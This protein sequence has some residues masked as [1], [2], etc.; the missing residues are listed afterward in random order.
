MKNKSQP[1]QQKNL[2]EDVLELKREQLRLLELQLKM[3]EGLPHLYGWKWYSW[4]WDFFESQNKENFL[5]AANQI[6]KS[7]TMI[8]KF[9]HWATAPD[10]WAG[11]W[12]SLQKGQ[13]PNQFWY[14]YPTQEVATIEFE[15]KWEPLFLPKG[16]Y[17]NSPQYGWKEEWDK[18]M[19]R[20]IRFNSGV[21]IY[22]K[23]Y[24]QKS[25]DLQTGTVYAIGA[26]EEM[27]VELLPELQAR[28][29]STDGY[30]H[31]VFT[32]TL[33]QLHWEQTLDPKSSVDEKHKGA[34]K[35]TVSLY[36]CLFYKDGSPSH[37]TE[38]KIRRAIAKC[39]NE[40]EVQR[41]VYGKFVRSHG[42]QY[43]G[44]SN[45]RNVTDP[46]LLPSTWNDYSGVDIGSGG[47]SGH[48]AGIIFVS[49]S[50]DYKRGRV[51]KAWR[52]DGVPTTA[53]DIWV[54]YLTLR[55]KK[56]PLMEKYDWASKDFG[57]ITN[58][59]GGAF[60]PADKNRESGV[61]LLNTLFKTGMLK[62]HRGDPELDKLIGE[63][64]SLAVG[65][66][67]KKAKDDLC[68]ALRYA[69]A[70]VPW[71]FSDFEV[72]TESEALKELPA[73]KEKTGP[74]MRR[75]WFMSE[76]EATDDIQAELDFWNEESGAL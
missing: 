71:D 40:A 26:D 33:G 58:R 41:R 24:S 27:P 1:L 37:W 68:D 72:S 32:A 65:A 17:K 34:W 70:S 74:E 67:K 57:M 15:T 12:P 31:M 20:N 13:V 36:D 25:K 54:K 55:G 48:P 50:P 47:M 61:G 28:L 62:I 6:S 35:R 39:P 14:F 59:K 10:H 4:A 30:F 51:Y 38:D 53:E 73:K 44:F 69:V 75:D 16:E 29:N 19:I 46:H 18:G 60:T 21:T 66:D 42:L 23:T 63:I 3:Q 22:F 2:S 9:I 49:V 7:S 5:C 11:L 43:E 52:G 45:E 76:K 64:C 56:I 8:R